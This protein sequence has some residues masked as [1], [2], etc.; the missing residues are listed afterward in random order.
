MPVG[1]ILVGDS[2]SNVEHDDTTVTIDVVTVSETSK[3]LLTGSIPHIE[4]E[5]PKVGEEAKGAI[6]N[7]ISATSSDRIKEDGSFMKR[8]GNHGDILNLDAQGG[9]IFFL[10]LTSQVALDESGLTSQEAC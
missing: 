2:G 1:N 5:L 8:R 6:N 4:L 7:T 10:E 9:D 3:L